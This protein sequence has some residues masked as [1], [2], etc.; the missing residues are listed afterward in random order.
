MGPVCH[1]S[2]TSMVAILRRST[3]VRSLALLLAATCA[4]SAQ[5]GPATWTTP[6][7]AEVD[8]IFPDI[9]SLYID[10]H[11]NPELAFQEIQTSAKLAARVKALGFDVTTGVGKTGI[12]AVLRNGAGPTGKGE[13]GTGVKPPDSSSMANTAMV[14]ELRLAA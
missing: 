12:V 6:T 9:D 11:R 13:P 2:T 1:N 10:L 14:F 4:V 7:T 8:A 5:S 3:T